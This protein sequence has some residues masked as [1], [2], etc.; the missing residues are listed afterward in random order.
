MCDWLELLVDRTHLTGTGII[1]LISKEYCWALENV[2]QG[3]IPL[4]SK[5]LVFYI[6]VVLGPGFSIYSWVSSTFQLTIL[7]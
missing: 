5:T 7:P 1:F 4:S 6:C 2:L 3:S